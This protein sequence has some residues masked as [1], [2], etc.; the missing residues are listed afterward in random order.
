M[1]HNADLFLISSNATFLL[2]HLPKHSNHSINFNILVIWKCLEI[3]WNYILYILINCSLYCTT[4]RGMK[5]IKKFFSWCLRW[6]I[7]NQQFPREKFFYI[8]YPPYSGV[9]SSA[10][11]PCIYAANF[12]FIINN[13][14]KYFA[15]FNTNSTYTIHQGNF[16]IFQLTSCTFKEWNPLRF[17]YLYSSSFCMACW[18]I[19]ICVPSI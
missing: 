3:N 8:T 11:V 13:L 4:S 14:S 6:L 16:H 17:T 9:M 1:V 5:L 2:I 15:Y 18:T 19:L 12:V 10:T 7:W